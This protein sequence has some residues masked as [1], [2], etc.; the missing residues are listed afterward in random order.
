[1]PLT[2][3]TYNEE[4]KYLDTLILK[5]NKEK[6][7]EIHKSVYDIPDVLYT[8]VKPIKEKEG[9][10]RYFIDDKWEYRNIIELEEIEL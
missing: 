2:I 9:F 6:S 5:A 3:Y 8:K 1:M 7:M 10:D 4:G